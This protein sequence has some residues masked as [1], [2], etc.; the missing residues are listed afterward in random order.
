MSEIQH[1]IDEAVAAY[2][3]MMGKRADLAPAV[4]KANRLAQGLVEAQVPQFTSFLQRIAEIDQQYADQALPVHF[5][6]VIGD[7]DATVEANQPG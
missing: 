2:A 4:E 6:L 5:Q 1:L 7:V 3:D